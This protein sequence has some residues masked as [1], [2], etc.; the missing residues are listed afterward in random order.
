MNCA[1]IKKFIA[2]GAYDKSFES[3]YGSNNLESA[4]HRFLEAVDGF[5]DTYG[6]MDSVELFSAP[7]RTEICGNHTDHNNG[8]VVAASVNLD[9]ISV[10]AKTD[11][12]IIRIK[13]KGYDIDVVDLDSLEPK[14]NEIN[15]SASLIRGTAAGFKKS[16]FAVGGLNAYTVSNVL[17][18]SG[19][20]SSAAFEVLIGTMLSSMYNND[21]VDKVKIAQTAQYA[22]NVY[23][24]KPCGLMDQMASSVGGIIAIDF[25]NPEK[26][27]I[28]KINYDFKNSGCALCIVDV[29]GD[30]A[31]L[32]DEYA[33]IPQEMKSVAQMF[34]AEVLRELSYE[35]I[36][37]NISD[38][39]KELGDRAALRA[40]HFFCENK[41]VEKIVK[42][43]N[44]D[45]FEQFKTI[46]TESG[47]S[48]YKYLQ[49]VFC[50]S[51]ISN[52]P[53]S[54]ALCLA[55]SLVNKKGAVRV[56]GGG[57]GGTIQCFV[58]VEMLD[59]F[60]SGIQNVFGK[61]SCHVLAIR[62]CGGIQIKI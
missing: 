60:K 36:F 59:D 31:D 58:P 13:S 39:R 37:E 15:K 41:R 35:K 19:L 33:S 6:D 56:H 21:R 48:S 18:G 40:I 8:K 57:F 28:E 9:I 44:S 30:H 2:D 1:E 7:G 50:C 26:P 16:G 17:K 27:V 49:N 43:L 62:S 23:F 10:A 24:G 47:S 25:K 53:M 61:E 5:L 42:A 12:N 32:T 14:E 22:E 55:E 51:D 29:G 4:K 52:Q 45:D 20:S 3:L 34:G 11:E 46:V 54:V 38:I